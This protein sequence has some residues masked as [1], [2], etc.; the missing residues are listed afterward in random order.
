LLVNVGLDIETLE[1]R[2]SSRLFR[3]SVK[4]LMGRDGQPH[5]QAPEM[6]LSSK[7]FPTGREEDGFESNFNAFDTHYSIVQEVLK[8]WCT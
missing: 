3:G 6:C 4:V 5:R 8:T 2:L 7:A 1:C